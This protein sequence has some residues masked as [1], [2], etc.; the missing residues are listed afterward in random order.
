MARAVPLAAWALWALLCAASARQRRVSLMQLNAWNAQ[1]SGDWPE[2]LPRIAGLLR[3]HLP[4]VVALQELRRRGGTQT[5]DQMARGSP[6]NDEYEEGVG[7]LSRGPLSAVEWAPLTWY[8]GDADPVQRVALHARVGGALDVYATHWSYLA[9]Q[10]LRNARD[11]L[12]F[13]SRAS[14]G[15]LAAAALLGDLNVDA[16]RTRATDVVETEAVGV[17]GRRLAFR[18]AWRLLRGNATGLTFSAVASKGGLRNRCDRVYVLGAVEPLRARVLCHD[19]AG[20]V[21]SDHCALLVDVVV[22]DANGTAGDQEETD[23]GQ[24]QQQQQQAFR[25]RPLALD[26]FVELLTALSLLVVVAVVYFAS[27]GW[28]LDAAA[29]RV[30][31]AAQRPRDPSGAAELPF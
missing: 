16:E 17:A 31:H 23:E 22:G 24:Q 13:V 4:D 9:A 28:P 15:P 25:P 29:R 5:P 18:D 21:Y 10:Q 14:E 11:T 3:A 1:D 8:A 20:A 7:L 12:A 6:R 30:P 19:S 2:R 27:G 26:R